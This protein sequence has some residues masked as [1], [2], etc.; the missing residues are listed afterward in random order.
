MFL[1]ISG[2]SVI[3]IDKN[4]VFRVRQKQSVHEFFFTFL[5]LPGP[6][7]SYKN[8]KKDLKF[9]P[10]CS[11]YQQYLF[12]N[13]ID[14]SLNFLIFSIIKYIFWFSDCFSSFLFL[15]HFNTAIYLQE[16]RKTRIPTF[17][18]NAPV[19]SSEDTHELILNLGEEGISLPISHLYFDILKFFFFI[20]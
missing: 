8:K 6:A 19:P 11:Q 14:S 10:F 18:V 13:N 1:S 17:P 15:L 9:L 20:G 2:F 12:K 5:W 3:H 4:K 16:Y 7:W